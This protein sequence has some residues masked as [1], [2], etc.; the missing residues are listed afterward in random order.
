M[1][2]IIPLQI[3]KDS[4]FFW[5]GG[6]EGGLIRLRTCCFWQL[7]YDFIQL[8]I[9]GIKTS[10]GKESIENNFVF[11]QLKCVAQWKL[12]LFVFLSAISIFFHM[13]LSNGGKPKRLSF[14]TY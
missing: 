12:N 5:G 6:D 11:P 13:Q 14:L 1:L 9:L 3:F 4:K 8:V 7:F 2:V 10:A